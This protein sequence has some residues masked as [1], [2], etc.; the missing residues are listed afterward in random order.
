MYKSELHKK[1]GVSEL[2]ERLKQEHAFWSYNIKNTD[3]ISEDLIIEK[4][5]IHLDIEDVI[6][7]YHLFPKRKIINVWKNKL[8]PQESIYNSLNRFYAFW[9]FDIKNPDKYIK[10]HLKN[11]AI[12]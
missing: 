4:V 12:N 2:I 11:T 10:A 3:E 6:K 8:L 5:L 7:L 9:L 1:E